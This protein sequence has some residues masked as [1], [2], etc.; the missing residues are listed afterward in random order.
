MDLGDILNELPEDPEEQKRKHQLFEELNALRDRLASNR[1]NVSDA[2]ILDGIRKQFDLSPSSD[3][4][5]EAPWLIQALSFTSSVIPASE[6]PG[7]WRKFQ[8]QQVSLQPLFLDEYPI[9][10]AMAYWYF[11]H[12]EDGSYDEQHMVTHALAL[13]EY[14]AQQVR[15][16]E[17]DEEYADLFSGIGMQLFHLYYGLRNKERAKFYAQLLE[18]EYLAGRLDSEDFLSVQEKA[19]VIQ[20]L[21][22]REQSEH[23]HILQ[24]HWETITDR[25]RQIEERNRRIEELER[26]HEETVDRAS[27]AADIDQATERVS[28]LCGLLWNRLHPLTKRNLSLGD[29]FSRAPLRSAHPD[30]PPSSFFKA[31][32]SELRARLFVPNGN[33]DAGILDRLKACSPASLLLEYNRI[34]TWDK[35]ED[36]ANIR[37][38]LDLIGKECIICSKANLEH[39]RRLR[40]H[41]NW[42][43]HPEPRGRSYSEQDL[44]D[45][46]RV[47]WHSNW[48]ISFLRQL[49]S[50]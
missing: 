48:L 4:I 28:K 35:K 50:H 22:H 38:S 33:L 49:H 34:V 8:K 46:L 31:L 20:K 23:E 19:A 25:E 17:A 24:L 2:E 16:W 12:R 1:S 32:N 13:Y 37:A 14:L 7:A 36:K 9:L 40:H 15:G 11:E 45:L 41:R 30:I 39:I 21:E 26:L 43:E 29:V 44:E 5:T 3:F 42:I 27:T 47:V 18:M 6:I 10:D